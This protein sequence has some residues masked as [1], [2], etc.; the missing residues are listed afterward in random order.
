MLFFAGGISG[1]RTARWFSVKKT[2]Q[3]RV[4][5]KTP[6]RACEGGVERSPK[7]DAG[8]LVPQPFEPHEA[9]RRV[10]KADKAAAL[11]ANT[12]RHRSR[13]RELR[14]TSR[15]PGKQVF[16]K[17]DHGFVGF[18]R[19]CGFFFKHAFPLVE[20]MVAANVPVCIKERF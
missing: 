16:F 4:F 2:R 14:G 7:A 10:F 9:S 12:W 20:S 8:I 6:D 13:M 18:L 11:S 3:W 5:R 17:T 19:P 15:T 1:I